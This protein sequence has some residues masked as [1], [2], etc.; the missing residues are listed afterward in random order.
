MAEILKS[1]EASSSPD[2]VQLASDLAAT[3]SEAFELNK[4]AFMESGAPDWL[5]SLTWQHLDHHGAVVGT[6]NAMRVLG[7][8]DDG[9]VAAS[10]VSF[11]LEFQI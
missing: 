8:A 7:T 6:T 4:E 2:L 9:R 1:P 5:V 11:F 3:S 10:K